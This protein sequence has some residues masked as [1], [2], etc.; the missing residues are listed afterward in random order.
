MSEKIEVGSSNVFKDLGCS[1]PEERL[2]KAELARQ[3]NAVIKRRNLA[4]TEAA[5]VIGIPK[6]KVSLLG[7]GIV[8]GFFLRRLMAFLNKLGQENR[9]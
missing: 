1:N 8:S 2:A 7:N 3:I 4:Q 5:E 9:V 6:Q